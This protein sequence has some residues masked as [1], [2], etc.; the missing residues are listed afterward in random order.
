MRLNTAWSLIDGIE[1]ISALIANHM[2][3]NIVVK[4]IDVAK[5]DLLSNFF[6][7]SLWSLTLPKTKTPDLIGGLVPGTGKFSNHFLEDLRLVV[8]LSAWGNRATTD[9]QCIDSGQCG[10]GMSP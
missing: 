7:R 1:V 9:S 2:T 6:L 5:C 8:D 3:G 4:G 10:L